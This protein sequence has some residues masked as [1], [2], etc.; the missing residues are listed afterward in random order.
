MD[1]LLLCSIGVSVMY[2]YPGLGKI[3]CC[4]DSFNMFSALTS[5]VPSVDGALGMEIKEDKITALTRDYNYS[6]L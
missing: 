1:A 2:P 5:A 6:A 4:C 3:S